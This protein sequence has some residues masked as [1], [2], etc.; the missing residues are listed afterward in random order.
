MSRPWMSIARVSV[1]TFPNLKQC[2]VLSCS[3]ILEMESLSCVVLG[4]EICDVIAGGFNLEG[5]HTPVY[6]KITFPLTKIFMGLG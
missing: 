3:Q 6:H 1:G 5:R 4:L 2:R